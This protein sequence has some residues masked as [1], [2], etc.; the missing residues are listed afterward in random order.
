VYMLLLSLPGMLGIYAYPACFA[1]GQWKERLQQVEVSVVLLLLSCDQAQTRAWRHDLKKK[2]QN[3]LDFPLEVKVQSETTSQRDERLCQS[4]HSIFVPQLKW[5]A[6]NAQIIILLS[7]SL[8]HSVKRFVQ[9]GWFIQ[10]QSRSDW[11]SESLIH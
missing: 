4:Q 5:N 10:G 2:P 6:K 8:N 7:Y 3:D 1:V 11:V 9:S